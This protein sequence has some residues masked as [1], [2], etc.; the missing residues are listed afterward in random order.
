MPI[1]PKKNT[2]KINFLIIGFIIILIAGILFIFARHRLILKEIDPPL[3]PE[4]TDADLTIK[5]FHHVATENSIKKWSLAAASA[6]LYSSKNI[7]ELNDVF[8]IFFMENNEEVRLR[9][10]SGELNSQTNDMVL[11]GDIVGIMP[12]YRLTT[13][14]LNYD[15]RS[16]MISAAAPV[17]I[18]GDAA[19]L[20]ADTMNYGLKSKII[21]CNGN[22]EGIFVGSNH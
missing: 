22:V 18:I 1:K 11:N 17:D 16:R 4:K 21:K 13:E 19:Q 14:S 8:V 12:P 10:D 2:R 20:K 6:R 3:P 15:H 9:A 7:V 5:K